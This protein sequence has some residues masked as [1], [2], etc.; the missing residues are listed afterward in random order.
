MRARDTPN[1]REQWVC[2]V[3]ASEDEASTVQDICDCACDH[4]KDGEV[5]AAIPLHTLQEGIVDV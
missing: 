2:P 5:D 1:N 4:R 3:N